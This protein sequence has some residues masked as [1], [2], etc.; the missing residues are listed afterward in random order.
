MEKAYLGHKKYR[1][2]DSERTPVIIRRPYMNTR[3]RKCP[4]TRKLNGVHNE[5]LEEHARD[6]E[7]F[8]GFGRCLLQIPD[9]FADNSD[10]N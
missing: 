10:S 5:A 3:D 9:R 2:Q 6:G 4:N 8:A 7:F 1:H